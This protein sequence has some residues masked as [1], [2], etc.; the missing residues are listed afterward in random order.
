M[1]DVIGNI[2]CRY[3]DERANFYARALVARRGSVRVRNSVLRD[4]CRQG[5]C[6]GRRALGHRA[7]CSRLLP[8]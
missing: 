5:Q 8:G 2:M 7:E 1:I 3:E 6:A 4:G